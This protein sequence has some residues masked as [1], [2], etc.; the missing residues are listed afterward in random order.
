AT[1]ERV[2]GPDHP[3]TLGSRNN[4]ANALAAG[5]VHRRWWRRREPAQTTLH[6]T[7]SSPDGDCVEGAKLKDAVPVRGSKRPT[8]P[9]LMFTTAEWENSSA[10]SRRENSTSPS[11][12]ASQT[13]PHA[14]G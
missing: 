5:R 11:Y 10:G 8:G 13:A 6:L 3:D 9:A 14:P 1:C 7:K 4:L 2:L 12:G